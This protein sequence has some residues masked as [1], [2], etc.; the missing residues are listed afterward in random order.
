[1]GFMLLPLAFFLIIFGVSLGFQGEANRVPGAGIAG[2]AT[3]RAGVI[4]QQAQT[5][6]SA[7]DSAAV[8]ASGTISNSLT[9][10]MPSGA[11]VPTKAVC[12]TVAN[13]GGGRV[14]Y[15]YMPAVP[16]ATAQIMAN[17]GYDASW[18]RV[19]TSGTAMSL[20]AAPSL[21][22]PTTIPTGSL[23]ESVIVNP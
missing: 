5:F 22:I 11:V 3:Y 10:T 16:G 23:L 12:A 21:T 8:T 20:A 19:N 17:T 1:M 6:A 13:P 14:V 7:C 15:A 9:I 2:Q 18:Y 4:A